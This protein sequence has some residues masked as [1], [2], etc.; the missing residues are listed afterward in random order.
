MDP[1]PPVDRDIPLPQGRLVPEYLPA[2]LV[3]LDG[4]DL[5]PLRVVVAAEAGLVPGD[6][7]WR[8]GDLPQYEWGGGAQ[9]GGQD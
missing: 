4:V 5:L 3:P 1:R 7:E 6:D 9:E 2:A 8:H